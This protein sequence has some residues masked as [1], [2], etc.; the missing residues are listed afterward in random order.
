MLL[1]VTSGLFRR[2]CRSQ[3]PKLHSSGGIMFIPSRV[4]Y[5]WYPMK[6]PSSHACWYHW[7]VWNCCHNWFFGYSQ[8]RI[9]SRFPD[10]PRVPSMETFSRESHP[11]A[12][13]CPLHGTFANIVHSIQWCPLFNIVHHCCDKPITY[14]DESWLIDTILGHD[15]PR[16]TTVP[17]S[18]PS[19]PLMRSPDHHLPIINHQLTPSED[20]VSQTVYHVPA[21]TKCETK[22]S[23][24]SFSGF[25]PSIKHH[26]TTNFPS[27]S[28]QSTIK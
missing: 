20:P 21:H 9:I 19:V 25:A 23:L 5:C 24:N 2:L 3:V 26:L 22:T 11:V 18:Q 8:R 16:L 27:S 14:A 12:G 4:Y 7:Y 6:V 28:H 15:Q 1:A 17:H 13:R 10:A